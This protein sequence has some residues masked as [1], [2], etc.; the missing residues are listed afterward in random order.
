MPGRAARRRSRKAARQGHQDG[1]AE[2]GAGIGE[3]RQ[4]RP[5]SRDHEAGE[6]R[7]GGSGSG[8]CEVEDRVALSQQAL[9]G[10]ER[11]DRSPGQ[12]TRA[13][14][15]QAVE[16]GDGENQSEAEV[17]G[18]NREPDERHGFA[19]VEHREHQPDRHR[20]E[21]GDERGADRC[22]QHLHRD[23]K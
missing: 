12:S 14:G 15:Q 3:Q 17:V 16:H 23:E 22:R 13:G 2:K 4:G 18:K 6:R 11:G 5:G 10:K 7:A 21:A 1:G 8:E 20:L 19:E 9:R